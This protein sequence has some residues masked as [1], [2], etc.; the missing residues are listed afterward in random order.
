VRSLTVKLLLAF[1]VTSVAGMTLAA[2]FIRASVVRE[3]DD[4]VTAQQRA[5]FVAE[6]GAYYAANGNWD[7]V[8]RWVRNR[9]PRRG[10]AARGGGGAGGP[11]PRRRVAP[12]GGRA[13]GRGRPKATGSACR[14]ARPRWRGGH[15]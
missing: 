15:R 11:P 13:G 3:F 4:Y 12:G 8:D 9:G 1:L 5:A 14:P 7:G 6:V 2:F 10:G